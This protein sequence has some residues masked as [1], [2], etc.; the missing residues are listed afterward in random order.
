LTAFAKARIEI[1][2]LQ[3]RKPCALDRRHQGRT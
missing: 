3:H 2:A 1:S